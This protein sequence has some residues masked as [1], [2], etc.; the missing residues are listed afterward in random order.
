MPI[1]ILWRLPSGKNPFPKLP[2]T[3]KKGNSVDK[4]FG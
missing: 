2:N 4:L 1:D 3:S